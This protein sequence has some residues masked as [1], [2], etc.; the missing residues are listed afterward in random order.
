MKINGSTLHSAVGIPV[1]SG[2][3][4]QQIKVARVTDKQL[5]KWKELDYII[6]D[7]V[8]MMDAKVMMQLNKTLNLLRG[9]HKEHEAKPFGGVNV[10]LFGDFFQLPSVSKLDLWRGKLGRWHQGHDLWRSLNAVV[11]LTQQMRQAEDPKF[12]EAMA[13]IRIHEPTDEDITMLNT[14]IG[15]P[16]PDSPAAPIIIRRHYVWH[17]INLQ[18]LQETALAHGM[19][20]VHCKAEVIASHGLSLHQL[21][22]SRP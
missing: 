11:T 16:I 10:L 21:Y 1:E 4:E 20:I 14:R 22:Y 12:A 15:A 17:A 5:L 13:R 3:R 6:V 8:S 2:N 18:K 9:S 7:E 19:P